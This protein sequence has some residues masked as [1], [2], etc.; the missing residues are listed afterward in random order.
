MID[1]EIPPETKAIRATV[2]QFVQDHCIPAE[3]ELEHR[4]F[5]EV[6][7]ELR[8][9]FPEQI[10]K[11]PISQNVKLAE[12]PSFSRTIFE[13]AP[14]SKGADD[15]LAVAKEFLARG[16]VDEETTEV[17]SLE[18]KA[19][20]MLQDEPPTLSDEEPADWIQRTEVAAEPPESAE[21]ERAVAASAASYRGEE[22]VQRPSRRGPWVARNAAH[23]HDSVSLGA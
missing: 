22:R 19:A 3:A 20:V 16:R 12:T 7:A 13:Y 17:R 15:Y 8:S 11:R 10:F 18:H 9:Y 4:D 6:L 5:D 14:D 21:A 23:G 1:F 2:R